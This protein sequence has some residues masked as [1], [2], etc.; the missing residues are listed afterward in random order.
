MQTLC[1]FSTPSVDGRTWDQHRK[2]GNKS[3]IPSSYSDSDFKSEGEF[4]PGD[5]EAHI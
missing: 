4:H 5:A 2:V 3:S 1:L